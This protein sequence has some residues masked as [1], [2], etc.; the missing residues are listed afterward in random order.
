MRRVLLPGLV[1]AL[2]T[3]CAQGSS[4]RHAEAPANVTYPI[5]FGNYQRVYNTTYHVVNRY[6]V[7]KKA[8]YHYGEIEAEVNQDNAFFD[9]TRRTILARI[10]DEGDYWDVECR[11]LLQVED[12]DVESLNEHQPRYNWR[13]I[14]SDSLLETKLNNEIKAAL[15]GGAWDSKTPLVPDGHASAAPQGNPKIKVVPAGEGENSSAPEPKPSNLRDA[16]AT[17]PGTVSAPALG[18][19]E[20]E[21]LGIHLLEQ[22]QFERAAQAFRAAREARP[23]SRY[24]SYL[25]AQALFATG[26]YTEAAL[27]IRDGA[28]RN[29]DWPRIKV[30]ARNFYG[31]TKAL[32]AQIEKLESFAK[33][34]PEDGNAQLVLGYV[35]YFIRD[36]R[37]AEQV[38]SS[39]E[40]AH[41]DDGL[42][43]TY[44][45]LAQ[46]E[47]DRSRGLEEF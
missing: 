4:V 30:D 46:V 39:I 45:K 41:P 12:S 5:A 28:A 27:A 11:V 18:D 21:Q 8:S 13:T 23:T 33:S 40:K 24:A 36:Y 20:C 25:L 32:K 10:F 26:D 15:S 31:E 43:T 9:K 29:P 16:H 14:A 7:V 3:G 37:R 19:E 35:S 34:H 22:G 1:L 17:T 2:V 42:A 6:A 47:L 38:F 44:R